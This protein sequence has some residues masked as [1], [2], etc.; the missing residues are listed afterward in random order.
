MGQQ[1]QQH[2]TQMKEAATWPFIKN[3]FLVVLQ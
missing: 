2:G 3:V 1:Q